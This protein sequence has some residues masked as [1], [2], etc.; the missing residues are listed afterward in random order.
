MSKTIKTKVISSDGWLNYEA[1]ITFETADDVQSLVD[2]IDQFNAI[3]QIAL[4]ELTTYS[5]K[6]KYATI[7]VE[8]G[9]DNVNF[10]ISR[11]LVSDTGIYFTL[12]DTHSLATFE[13]GEFSI[14]D[15]N[16]IMK[17]MEQGD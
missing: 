5:V 11:V 2:L 14:D 12:L 9:T 10:D 6:N 4:G 7:K 15:L 13:I 17:E 1:E 16:N 8:Q 3:K